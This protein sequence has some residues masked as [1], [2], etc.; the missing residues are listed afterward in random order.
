[1]HGKGLPMG[2]YGYF[3]IPE[4]G[5]WCDSQVFQGLGRTDFSAC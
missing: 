2:S 1:M 5:D 4:A 3:S